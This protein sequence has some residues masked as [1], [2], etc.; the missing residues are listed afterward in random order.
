M[1][2]TGRLTI[3]NGHRSISTTFLCTTFLL[4]LGQSFD[5][6]IVNGWFGSKKINKLI[7]TVA[8]IEP[9]CRDNALWLEFFV[10]SGQWPKPGIPANDPGSTI[11]YRFYLKVIKTFRDKRGML[12]LRYWLLGTISCCAI[13]YPYC[14]YCCWALY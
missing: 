13:P 9:H 5:T 8:L 10:G 7:V 14:V 4:F 12:D 3:L 1:R 2:H 11:D 6:F